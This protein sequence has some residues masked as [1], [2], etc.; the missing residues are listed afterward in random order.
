MQ[1]SAIGVQRRCNAAGG[2][3]RPRLALPVCTPENEE[4]TR[5]TRAPALSTLPQNGLA[6][7][8]ADAHKQRVIDEIAELIADAMYAELL[9]DSAD[10]NG[11]RSVP[12]GEPSVT[13]RQ[14]RRMRRI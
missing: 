1:R 12:H 14:I 3:R 6:I 9:S 2:S 4:N 5:T 10:S 8:V 13:S 7:A 11:S